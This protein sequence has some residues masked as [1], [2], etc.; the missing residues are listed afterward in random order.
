[1]SLFG[2][3]T[4][5]STPIFIRKICLDD[6]WQVRTSPW[7]ESRSREILEEKLLLVFPLELEKWIFMSR[8]PLD[9]QD[10][11][12]G[13]QLMN[14]LTGQSHISKVWFI[15]L[16]QVS[17]CTFV[18]NI[19]LISLSLLETGDF[20]RQPPQQCDWIFQNYNYSEFLPFLVLRVDFYCTIK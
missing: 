6:K 7:Q 11:L 18:G 17:K 13:F 15:V 20:S 5:R 9:F 3:H 4:G 19:F 14:I 12:V 2:F 1:M 16:Y 10:H 8:S